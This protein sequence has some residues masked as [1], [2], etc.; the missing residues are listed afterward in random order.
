MIF[1]KTK[2]HM[3]TY[4]RSDRLEIIAYTDFDFAR[5]QDSK[6]STTCYIFMLVGGTVSWKSAKQSL[7]VTSTME[8]VFVSYFQA[9]N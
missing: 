4:Q 3:L 9:S 1:T 2:H 7:I 6:K 5:C 8:V